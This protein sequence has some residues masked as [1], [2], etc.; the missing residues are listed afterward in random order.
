MSTLKAETHMTNVE[1]EQDLGVMTDGSQ[2]EPVHV[3]LLCIP[4]N[5]NQTA[6]GLF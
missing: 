5:I 3:F 2:L 4:A 6:V 1:P